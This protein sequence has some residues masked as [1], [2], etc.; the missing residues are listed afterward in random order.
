MS[1]DDGRQE[2][3]DILR[4][5]VATDLGSNDPTCFDFDEKPCRRRI[6]ACVRGH[7]HTPLS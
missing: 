1:V 5:N 4:F 3:S 2:Y 6:I 7:T